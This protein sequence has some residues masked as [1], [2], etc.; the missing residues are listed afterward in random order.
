MALRN[1]FEHFCGEGPRATPACTSKLV[2]TISSVGIV[3]CLELNTGKPIWEAT[4]LADPKDNCIFGCVCSPLIIDDVVIISAGRGKNSFFALDLQTG[5]PRW[6]QPAGGA[7]YCSPQLVVIN[8]QP[9]IVNFDAKGL[10][11]HATMTEHRSGTFRGS[12][13]HPKMNNVCSRLSSQNQR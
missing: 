7:S 9:L 12:R 5:K 1:L 6:Q 8:G 2:V 10:F 13:I 3:S 11:L 4:L